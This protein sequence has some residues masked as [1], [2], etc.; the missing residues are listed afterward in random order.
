MVPG[1]TKVLLLNYTA[2]G[3]NFGCRATSKGLLQLIRQSYPRAAIVRRPISFADPLDPVVLPAS[4]QGWDEYLEGENGSSIYDGFSRADVIILNGEGSIHE[5]P[6]KRIR[7]EPYLRLLEIYAAVRVFQKPV[8]AVNQTIDYWSDEFAT[9][10]KTSYKGCN[11]ISVREPRSLA[12]LQS[13]G[14][15]SVQLVPDAAFLTT[16]VSEQRAKHFL[17]RKGIRQGYIALFLGELFART[18]ADKLRDLL[19]RLLR[20]HDRQVVLYATD[21]VDVEMASHIEDLLGAP[22]VGLDTS[23]EVIVGA[24]SSASLVLSGR[25]HACVFA[26]LAGTPLVPFRSN[27]Y[28]NEGLMEMLRYPV[29]VMD[30]DQADNEEVLRVVGDVME[31]RDELRG[32]FDDTVPDLRNKAQAGYPNLVPK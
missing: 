25:F 12:R 7:P 15:N 8:M 9:W 32:I 28:K 21:R 14:L 30:Y 10:V 5:W 11:Y 23:P 1:R 4:P 6:D 26:A 27:T 31:H 20:E 24:L 18:A 22:V 2:Y 29:E 17:D 19:K 3:A 16:A 13:L